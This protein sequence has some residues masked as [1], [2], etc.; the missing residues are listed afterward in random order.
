MAA[1]ATLDLIAKDARFLSSMNRVRRAVE[2]VKDRM[3]GVA[4]SA[5]RMLL[6]GGVAIAGFLALAGQQIA[7]ETKLEAVLKATGNAAGISAEQLKAHAAALQDITGVGDEVVI[8]MQ[9][10]LATFKNVR[11]DEFIRA[12]EAIVDMSVVLGT[13]LQSA[14]IQ[15]G[16]A[17]NDPI[18]GVSML[19]RSGITFTETQLAM[20]K[21]LA[22]A[23]D[24]MGAQQIVLKE[25][26]TQFGGAA[27]AIGETFVGSMKKA[28]SAIGDVGEGIGE[29]F[30]PFVM[31][32]AEAVTGSK[33]GILNWV[34]ANKTLILGV[35]GTTAALA[36]ATI[37]IHLMSKAIIASTMA[38]HGLNV[39]LWLLKAHPVIA[40]LSLL[41]AAVLGLVAYLKGANK[42]T[43]ELLASERKLADASDAVTVAVEKEAT[44]IEKAEERKE[45]ARRRLKTRQSEVRESVKSTVARLGE[46]LATYGMTPREA[47][48]SRLRR[49]GATDEQLRPVEKQGKLLDIMEEQTRTAKEREAAIKKAAKE[50]ESLRKGKEAS[51]KTEADALKELIKTEQQKKRAQLDRVAVLEKAGRLTAEEAALAREK[52]TTEERTSRTAAIED[53]S[54]MFRRI[55]A[56][57]G[58][59]RPDVSATPQQQTASSTTKTAASTTKI[60][61][62]T[63]A[64][65][66]TLKEI[67]DLLA[68]VI[69][70]GLKTQ[71]VFG[72]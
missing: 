71:A 34:T 13:D 48:L 53:A 72:S 2:R 30:I 15:V 9:A 3:A 57:A 32:M 26:E 28:K 35:T 1:K 38:V 46:K 29:V 33:E 65:V 25:L 68:E 41:A 17:L 11:G 27:E 36:M 66:T 42:A 52:L 31:K 23:G 40:A 8:A 37:G 60:A 22:K 54:S 21:S 19:S 45:T 61:E 18:R 64:S 20:I 58:G 4:S 67:Y 16:K 55:Q 39:A 51:L 62:Q 70:N 6:I 5:K 59:R 14:A 24:M 10:V 56:A 69:A 50:E 12:T 43:E 49:G 44:A 7:A 47:E 63:R